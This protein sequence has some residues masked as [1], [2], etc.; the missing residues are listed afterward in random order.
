MKAAVLETAY[1]IVLTEVPDPEP[2]ADEV[3]V[4]VRACGVSSTDLM[5]FEGANPWALQAG[6]ARHGNA[7]NL[8]LGHEI[9]GTVEAVGKDVAKRLVGRRVAVIPFH[10][11][12]KCDQCLAHRPNLCRTL[13]RL[14]HNTGWTRRRLYPG[15]MSE[16]CAVWAS[17]CKELPSKLS[18]E[19]ATFLDS[20][21]TA[22]HAVNIAKVG[23][24]AVVLVIGC[25]PVGL[26]LAQIALKRGA[27]KVFVSDTYP[28]T[29]DV[30][31]AVASVRCVRADTDDLTKVVRTETEGAGVN[32]VFD[33]VGI[34]E[35][36]RQARTLLAPGGAIVNLALTDHEFSLTL[37]D[38]TGE[39]SMTTSVNYLVE[40]FTEAMKTLAE[41]SVKVNPYITHRMGLTELPRVIER[42][43]VRKRHNALKAVVFP[44]RD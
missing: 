13:T 19:D 27:Q 20:L 6:E 9:A 43:R 38:L 29:L 25:G 26:C 14:G 1:R 31:A 28:L 39:R 7:T 44:D 3:L 33:T 18:F 37:R 4:R 22:I 35:T 11:C 21:A 10:E 32:F 42:L 40:E 16:L 30:A 24:R 12:G 2:E 8:I 23:K 15:G 36:Q 34:P 17:S 5:I 41:G